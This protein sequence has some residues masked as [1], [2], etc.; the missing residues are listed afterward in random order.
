[1]GPSELAPRKVSKGKQAEEQKKRRQSEL[2]EKN[3][4]SQTSN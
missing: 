4:H 2:P 1:M 3:H